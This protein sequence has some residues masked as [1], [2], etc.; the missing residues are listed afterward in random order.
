MSIPHVELVTHTPNPEYMMAR[1]ARVSNPKNQDNPKFGKLLRYMIREK[2]YSPFEHASLTLKVTTTL[3]IATQ[4]LR[5]RSFTFQQLSRRYAG[6]KEAPVVMHIPE[7]RAPHPKNRQ[8]SVETLPQPIQDMYA[9]HINHL[10]TL[11]EELY[12]DMLEDGVAKECARAVLPQATQTTLHMTGSCRSWLHYIALRGGNGTQKEHMA[13][14]EQAKG[15]FRE[16][17]P[18]VAGAV[19]NL[20]WEI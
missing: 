5:H 6:D 7:L 17:F 18:T 13:V 12:Q 1:V 8:K 3:D 2:H 19:D 4:I 16:V 11:A 15:I 9:R 14:A 20:N 10:F